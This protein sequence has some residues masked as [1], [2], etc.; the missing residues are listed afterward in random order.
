MSLKNKLFYTYDLKLP[1]INI[2]HSYNSISEYLLAKTKIFIN[3]HNP[4]LVLEKYETLTYKKYPNYIFI[5]SYT[6]TY[7][8]HPYLTYAKITDSFITIL[9]PFGKEYGQIS[10]NDVFNIIDGI[11]DDK[12]TLMQYIAMY[13]LTLKTINIRQSGILMSDRYK[14][15]RCGAISHCKDKMRQLAKTYNQ[16]SKE[17]TELVEYYK[18]FY[19]EKGKDLLIKYFNALKD[20]DFN[21]AYAFLKGSGGIKNKYFGRERLNTFFINTSDVIGHL[22]IFIPLYEILHELSAYF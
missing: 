2:E 8:N 10:F 20:G 12:P 17:Y 14:I 11:D 9:I 18:N 4:S 22:Q 3:Y 6:K 15:L 16:T 13:I 7:T 21:D 5:V 19:Y 1:L